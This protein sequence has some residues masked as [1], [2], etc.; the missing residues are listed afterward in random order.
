M[1]AKR[2]T[3]GKKLH[4]GWLVMAAC[5]LIQLGDIGIFSNCGGVFIQPV[6]DE[7]GFARADFQLYMSIITL[8]MA[9]TM[10]LAQ[11]I[12]TRVNLRTLVSACVALECLAFGMMSQYDSVYGWYISGLVLGLGHAYLT[13]LLLPY[14]LN[15][16]FKVRY[17]LALGLA[18]CCSTLGGAIFSP[19]TGWL[20][21]SFGW[22]NAY[23][24]LAVCAFII[25]F[26]S[27]AIILRREP[28]E[29][30]LKP[31]G[32]GMAPEEHENEAIIPSDRGFT[33]GQ[34]V[35]SPLFWCCG[36]F[37]IGLALT[38]DFLNY[39]SS[40]AYTLGFPVETGSMIQS[41][42][43]WAAVLGDPISG[44]LRDRFGAGTAIGS[45][46]TLG[47]LGLLIIR[48]SGGVAALVCIGAFLFGLGF[49]LLNMAP[50]LLVK[51][52]VGEKEYGRI[53]SYIAS[54][55]TL[56]SA[57]AAFIYGKI[58]DLHQSYDWAL[59]F[60]I[61]SL[62]VSVLISL[63]IQRRTKGLWTGAAEAKEEK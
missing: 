9:L 35:R 42:V 26:P 2:A 16:W 27:A 23:I 63:Y 20:I 29:K 24:I 58:Y 7:L 31:Y 32:E 53:Y 46:M 60:A 54:L 5:G 28:E 52:V 30:G 15:N 50:P 61:V 44:S 21:G 36:V 34:A 40:L 22:R 59:V 4:Y 47:I 12:L 14:L 49:S 56:A 48:L 62:T 33:L 11:R 51:Q 10:P 55:L 3:R 38:C 19:V 25:A 6:C 45:L 13:Y 57:S 43:L 39:I 37:V 8:T 1:E 41:L 17:G 18:C